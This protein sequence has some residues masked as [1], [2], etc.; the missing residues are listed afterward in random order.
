M[1]DSTSVGAVSFSLTL[2]SSNLQAEISRLSQETESQVGD[3]LSG[4]QEELADAATSAGTEIQRAMGEAGQSVSDAAQQMA[5]EIEICM[6]N[7][8]V[9]IR[10]SAEDMQESMNDAMDGVGG[11][12]DGAMEDAD[13]SIKENSNSIIDSLKG[14]AKAVVAAFAIDK[15]I[16]FSEEC[17]ELGSDLAEVQNVV[18]VTFT[19][20]S[21]TIDDFAQNAASQ[22]GLSETMAKQYAG[23]FG[24]M[25][26]A[27]GFTEEQAANMSM[28][29][30]GLAGDVASFYNLNQEEAYTKL[31]SVFTGETESLK[32]LG[33][34]MTQTALDSYA[35]ANGFGK[36]TANMT[37]AEKVSLRYAFVQDQLATASGDFAR[38]SDGWANQVRI[39]NLQIDS[40]K[41]TIGQGLINAFTPVI[42]LVNE[43]ISRL[44]VLATSFKNFTD[45][46]FGKQSTE[47]GIS[48]AALAADE[49][50]GSLDSATDSADD[51]SDAIAD[52][53]ESATKTAQ[54][55]KQ[56][57]GFDQINKLS[58]SSTDSSSTTDT[59]STP[60]TSTTSTTTSS[61]S[62]NT[63][64]DSATVLDPLS[65]AIENLISRMNE[66][67]NLFLSGFTLGLGDLSVFDSI[68]DNIS[69]I[70]SSL[71]SIFTDSEV[72]NAANN[73]SDSLALT[74]GKITGSFTS[75]GA[76][77]VD[78]LTGGMA[79]YLEEHK[80]DLK[81]YIVNMFDV[82]TEISDMVGDFAV[83]IA[84]IFTVFR[85][86]DAKSITSDF[87]DLFAT[88]FT[89]IT[90]L[91]AKVFRD[92]V[93]L[94]TKPI[95][96]NADSI[97]KALENTLA[98][99]STVTGAIA[100][101]WEKM[102]DG[103]QK[104]YD[105]H[106]KPLV[107]SLATGISNLISTILDGYNKW[108]APVL[109]ALADDFAS[110]MEKHVSPALDSFLEA[111]GSI[112]DLV[113][114]LWENI[115]QPIATFLV[116][117]LSPVIAALAVILG[118]TLLAAL[119]LISD[120]FGLLCDAVK[121][122]AD[123]LSGL[124]SFLG[125]IPGAA[126]DVWDGIVNAFGDVAGWF[127]DLFTDAWDAITGAFT[128]VG[129]WFQK[130]VVDAIS[131]VVDGV[132]NITISVGGKI[133]DTFTAAKDAFD[134]VKDKT[135]EVLTSAKEKVA[136]AFSTIA[137][138]FEGI[139]D[140][141][142]EMVASAKEKVAGAISTLKNGWDSVADKTAEMK[143]KV[144]STWND[145]KSKWSGIT[146][147]IA[148]KTAD[149]KAKVASTWNDLKSKWSGITS[150]IANK[151]AD[152]KAKVASTWN[153]LKS[154][155][156]S[157]TSKIA[158]K[159]ADMKAKVASTWND[160]KSKW[161]SITS[162]IAGKTADMKA[163]VASTWGELKAKWTSL[164]GNFKDHTVN[165]SL[166]IASTA[167]GIKD[168]VNDIIDSVNKNLIANIKFTVPNS[169]PVIGG[170]TI[171]PPAN[172]PHL[173]EG[174]FVK[175]NTPRL[176]VIGDN[177][178]Y[179]EIVAPEN[180]LAAMAKKAA[181]GAS[182]GDLSSVLEL[183]KQIIK[184]LQA[185][186][187]PIYLNGKK[188]T[189]N[190]INDIN[191][192]TRSTGKSPLLI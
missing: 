170:T 119:A 112:V 175:A 184:L 121:L 43:L 3:A 55:M 144:A 104:L 83:A 71:K 29:L 173:A 95:T 105:E 49:A 20:M 66:L 47:S 140:K 74:F 168:A 143:A 115:L 56:L 172:I 135:A 15:I 41:A 102:W 61:S 130:N 8:T 73:L 145:L 97:K 38:T 110:V 65:K 52:A 82:A 19:T 106:I 111:I 152:M 141:T 14:I 159:T 21:S 31:K 42:K 120:A 125:D 12:V 150:N 103:I 17:L 163:K 77:I 189:Q 78:N 18:D 57:M 126:S 153:D 137:D 171:G 81:Q 182:S 63:I 16:S 191:Q 27:F 64:T 179:G 23:T 45:V 51:L 69:S 88:A 177:T 54:K 117:I 178:R 91:A 134:N 48:D 28:T 68:K 44:S 157:I 185:L 62:A 96:D 108:I 40:L 116:D 4:V 151:T 127:G 93:E 34:V 13:N 154:K 9:L 84:D 85:S 5:N 26:T 24:A 72:I 158:G 75:I 192:Q 139:K 36:T 113:K 32:D 132:K 148:N 76:T 166:K 10:N 146:S 165:L 2:D 92:I 183:L 94:I 174:G 46:V 131:G 167:K 33:V 124:V 53:G 190:T 70:G 6:G 39:L 59:S 160:L 37:E 122:I 162:K 136:G 98:P 80:D 99:L 114:T 11:S 176:A 50:T 133:G 101:A 187:R 86:D 149:M 169:I 181:E 25:A 164:L 30:T 90:E 22:F 1:S 35:L 128:G 142:V 138:K 67:K 155:W 129:D 79:K 58:D 87:I 180:K 188:I 186:D 147:N 60:S 100:D 109:Q 123:G 118:E 156:S 107:D 7:T 161:S 89:N